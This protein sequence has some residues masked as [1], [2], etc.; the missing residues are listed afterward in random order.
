MS[1]RIYG[2]RGNRNRA[3]RIRQ[4]IERGEQVEES[5]QD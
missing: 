3:D 2:R 1:A 5:V 4:C